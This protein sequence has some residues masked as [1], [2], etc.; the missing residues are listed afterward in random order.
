MIGIVVMSENRNQQELK[1]V[2]KKYLNNEASSA[3]RDAIDLWYEEIGSESKGV[4]ALHDLK[5]KTKIRKDIN[6]YLM[7]Q[8]AGHR[9]EWYKMGFVKYAAAC[10]LFLGVGLVGYQYRVAQLSAVKQE[11]VIIAGKTVQKQLVLTDGTEV[12]LNVDSK[13]VIA[14]DFGDSTRQVELIGEAFFKVAKDKTKPFFIRSGSLK[15]RVIGTSFNIN[16]YPDLEK[17]KIAVLSGKV[18]VFATIHGVEKNLAM[19]MVKNQTLS[20]YISNQNYELKTEDTELISSWRTNKLY[21]DNANIQDIAKQL[22]RYYHIKVVYTGK[23]NLQDK[24]TI[25]FS[26]ESMNGVLQILSAL[27]KKNFRYEN[28]Q[29][30]IK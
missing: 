12:L 29:I 5:A 22:E 2:L 8:L 9:K 17:V 14:K 13:L 20:F 16:A 15:T 4:S 6:S 28:K 25:R 7:L 26:N 3:E 19:G 30:T 1:A 10:V 24:Y 27:T 18:K 21:I 11:L 23:L